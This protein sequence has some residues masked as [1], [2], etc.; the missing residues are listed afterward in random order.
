[1][2]SGMVKKLLVIANRLLNQM[3]QGKQTVSDEEILDSLLISEDPAFTTSELADMH[4]MTVEG[5]RG[6]LNSL[7]EENEI[8]Q[9]KPGERSVIWWHPKDQSAPLLSQ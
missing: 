4:G 5:M 6:R 2:S 7:A 9:K 8:Q 1:M 3:P